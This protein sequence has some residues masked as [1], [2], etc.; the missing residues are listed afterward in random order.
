MTSYALVLLT[1]IA[2]CLLYLCLRLSSWWASAKARFGEMAEAY[3]K[4]RRDGEALRLIWELLEA[5]DPVGVWVVLLF[6]C[7][8]LYVLTWQLVEPWNLAVYFH[9]RWWALGELLLIVCLLVSLTLA[10]WFVDYVRRQQLRLYKER[11]G[12]PPR[13]PW[14]EPALPTLP[15]GPS[16][17]LE[18]R[19]IDYKKWIEALKLNSKHAGRLVA[20]C[21][22][23]ERD[24]ATGKVISH[25]PFR[26]LEAAMGALSLLV[27]SGTFAVA[28]LAV[29]TRHEHKEVTAEL[30]AHFH[31]GTRRV[32][33]VGGPEQDHRL[34]EQVLGE[35]VRE[36]LLIKGVGE[37]ANE[38]P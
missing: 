10:L 36:L 1:I 28:R 35:V 14:S 9:P 33:L 24:L 6:L 7:L 23:I 25:V 3:Q 22:I 37:V 16:H 20:F 30:T 27:S 32:Q 11:G 15:K 4:Y 2:A 17:S 26:H 8:S 34:A 19:D 18:F 29:Y 21:E 38:S 5:G 31:F 12:E 13:E